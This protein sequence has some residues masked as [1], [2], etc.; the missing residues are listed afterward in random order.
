T[1]PEAG[2]LPRFQ[3]KLKCPDWECLARA[4]KQKKADEKFKVRIVDFRILVQPPRFS[5]KLRLHNLA[6]PAIAFVTVQTLRV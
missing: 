4:A 2:A 3:L 5:L 1:A 6:N